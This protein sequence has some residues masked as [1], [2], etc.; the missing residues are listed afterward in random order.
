MA[1]S[2][3]KPSNLLALLNLLAVGC[4]LPVGSADRQRTRRRL[5][6]RRTEKETERG[7]ERERKE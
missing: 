3:L 1:E 5:K 2:N 7:R 6:D 4:Q